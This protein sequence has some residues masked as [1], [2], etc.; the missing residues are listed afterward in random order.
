MSVAETTFL[1]ATRAEHLSAAAETTPERVS[2][3]APV[4]LADYL[5]GTAELLQPFAGRRRD[6]VALIYPGRTHLFAGESESGKSWAALSVAAERLAEGESVVYC[7]FEDHA[8]TLAPRLL[9]I[10]VPRDLVLDGFHYVRPDHRLDPA[11]KS[12]LEPLLTSSSLAVIDGVTEAMASEGLDPASDVD[13]ATFYN[14]VTRW[15]AGHGP[16]VILVD[17]VVKAA[18]ARGRWATGSQ[19][20]ISGLTGAAYTFERVHPMG[21]GLR[22]VARV[23]V[24]KDRGGQVRQHARRLTGEDRWQIADFVVDASDG[25]LDVYFDE[26]PDLSD[27][28]PTQVMQRISELLATAR[29]PLSKNMIEQGVEAKSAVVRAALDLLVE[30]DYVTREPGPRSAFLHS[31]KQPFPPT[32]ETAEDPGW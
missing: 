5:D 19:H 24:G 14:R 13:V 23:L 3:W 28:R 29:T 1:D 8:S 21:R 2:T 12:V 9:D 4:P 11:A 20:K 7:D 16:A 32:N 27:F 30:E 18:A 10:G 15:M 22:G 25:P 26:P 17:H 6:G 31:L